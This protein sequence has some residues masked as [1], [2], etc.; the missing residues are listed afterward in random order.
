MIRLQKFIASA[1]ITSRRK[2]ES[3][4]LQG[5]V[6]VNGIRVTELGT[7]V[8]PNS[9]VVMLD[10]EPIDP[11]RVQKIYI[12]LNKP[13]GYVT[14]L[15]D[16]EGRKTVMD[17]VHDCTE[18]IYPVGRLDYLSEGLLLMTNDGE[19]ANQIIHPSSQVVKVY[20]VK[21]FGAVSDKIL[22][23]LRNGV[24]TEEGFLKPKSARVVKQ[25]SNKTWLEFRLTDGKNREIRKI[26]EACDMTVDKLK[27]V[28]IGG[29]AIEGIRPG[30]YCYITKKNLLDEIGL[31]AD[32][33]IKVEKEYWSGKKTVN[34]KSKR[35]QDCTL[36]DSKSFWKFRRES[37]FKTIKELEERKKLE[38]ERARREAYEA[39][40]EAYQKRK[41]KKEAR[42]KRKLEKKNVGI[43]AV[44]V[45]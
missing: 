12:V 22:K 45:K 20:E 1:G 24:Q 40:E 2:A 31:K 11:D 27:R 38:A 30:S 17:L 26:C 9:D 6:K 42:Q 19:L 32:G 13:R 21:V 41:A 25:L 18:R 23:K 44:E 28:A 29:L 10:N 14:T 7:K 15:S 36:A 39:K 35:T 5:R 33:S 34:L 4:I 37:Y 43:H 16:P 3:L 8:I